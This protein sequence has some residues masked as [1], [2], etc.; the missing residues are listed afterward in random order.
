MQPRCA[1]P[2]D[3]DGHGVNSGTFLGGG[4]VAGATLCEFVE[5]VMNG[6]ATTERELR[7]TEDE[8]VGWAHAVGE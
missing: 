8:D 2:E 3:T 6:G 4:V 5:E 7:V 1:N